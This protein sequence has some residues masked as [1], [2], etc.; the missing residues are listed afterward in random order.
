MFSVRIETVESKR[1][2][3]RWPYKQREL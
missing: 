2:H 1:I 3:R